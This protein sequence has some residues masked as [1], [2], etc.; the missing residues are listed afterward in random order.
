VIAVASIGI[1]AAGWSS[2]AAAQSAACTGNGKISKQ[3]AKPMVAAQDAMKAKKWQEAL[4]KLRE[5][6]A[7][8]G[9]KSQFD[10]FNISE[11]RSFIYSNLH[12]N[13]ELARELE[14]GLNRWW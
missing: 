8:P 3:I 12:Q 10:L 11:F 7:V 5:V 1:L 14:T 9:A 4:S 13:A 2:P 6:D